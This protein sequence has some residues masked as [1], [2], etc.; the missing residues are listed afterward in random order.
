ME[1]PNQRTERMPEEKGPALLILA[2][3]LGSRF[4]G[5]KQVESL[6]MNNQSI[7]DYSIY[8]AI[9]AGFSRIVFV[10]SRE[11]ESR[12]KETTFSRF[13][14]R[15]EID[16]VFQD[17][18]DVPDG[19][20]ISPERKKPWGT[21]HA[22]LVAE[23]AIDTPFAVINADDFYGAGSFRM[24]KQELDKK[25]RFSEEFCM[26]GYRLINT[27]SEFGGVSRGLCEESDGY[28]QSI[29]EITDIKKEGNT[30][31]GRKNG[32]RI[33]LDP[34]AIVSMN[35]WGFSLK[36]FQILKNEFKRFLSVEM[37]N[38]QSE[39]FI[40]DVLDFSIK[41]GSSKVRVLA[42]NEKWFGVTYREDAENVKSRLA[43]HTRAGN[44]PESL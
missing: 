35:F 38:L 31:R 33:E 30:I 10:V 19:F 13:S 12:L 26:L 32:E 42:T 18:E 11:I 4:G 29:A 1:T 24:M 22:V 9:N 15:I 5:T 27:L 36:I 17:L 8:D 16:Y 2:A 20:T 34:N 14:D 37:D 7:M 23:N 3:G 44:Y 28:L 6:G 41:S 43:S 40:T 21:A 39:F 25:D